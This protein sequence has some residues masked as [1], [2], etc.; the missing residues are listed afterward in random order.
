MPK[1]TV[2]IQELH[3]MYKKAF[4]IANELVEDAL[5]LY[6]KE[7]YARAYYLAQAAFEEFGKLN[8]L[9]AQA[10]RVYNKEKVTIKEMVVMKI[11]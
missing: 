7:S 5:T 10:L 8:M 6:K 1:E 4:I 3:I 11:L 9:Y 2:N